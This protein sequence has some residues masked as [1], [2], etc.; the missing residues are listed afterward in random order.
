MA[1]TVLAM[2]HFAR[3][4]KAELLKIDGPRVS[5]RSAGVPYCGP[6]KT[7]AESTVK[8]SESIGYRP[9]SSASRS[10]NRLCC[11]QAWNRRVV[12]GAPTS[13]LVTPICAADVARVRPP[14][15]VAQHVD[16]GAAAFPSGGFLQVHLQLE[17]EVGDVA[18]A[19]ADGAAIAQG[20]DARQAFEQETHS[21]RRRRGCRPSRRS[22]CPSAK[23][24][25]FSS[26]ASADVAVKAKQDRAIRAK[27]CMAASF[28]KA[29]GSRCSPWR[30]RHR[31]C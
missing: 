25:A 12:V 29:S 30:H 8:N 18:A 10:S 17:I 1:Y 9:A 21:S 28:F 3:R 7:P 20:I 5:A 14:A 15:A 27:R 19:V 23:L 16:H 2:F 22:A 31:S 4:P 11:S 24:G 26:S 6:R 13:T